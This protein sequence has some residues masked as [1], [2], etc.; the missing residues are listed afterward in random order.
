MHD[1]Q[2][3]EEMKRIQKEV[4]ALTDINKDF[5]EFFDAIPEDLDEEGT[6]I[7]KKAF[8]FFHYKAI[9]NK[10]LINDYK[11]LSEGLDVDGNLAEK[12]ASFVNTCIEVMQTLSVNC[13]NNLLSVSEPKTLE[14]IDKNISKL[15]ALL[16]KI[17]AL[18][19]NSFS[20]H[21]LNN[22]FDTSLR[23]WENLNASSSKKLTSVVPFYDDEYLNDE[24]TEKVYNQLVT[25][26]GA[27]AS[28]I[29]KYN[30]DSEIFTFLA[31]NGFIESEKVT[32]QNA[33]DYSDTNT[34]VFHFSKLGRTAFRAV[35]S[36]N[37]NSLLDNNNEEIREIEG[38]TWFDQSLSV[39][40]LGIDEDGYSI[41]VRE[42][43]INERRSV[44]ESE[45]NETF[46]SIIKG[47][48]LRD[49]IGATLAAIIGSAGIYSMLFK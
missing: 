40:F 9:E 47:W 18:N 19:D 8:L 39:L 31:E 29:K 2:D 33:M 27:L 38:E 49:W 16:L 35:V 11:A 23:D 14:T 36:N 30:K 34:T 20:S 41:D 48:G 15:N 25:N 26:A 32:L 3:I 28:L 12:S 21:Y 22:D 4:I 6:Y 17:A 10:S 5:S 43:E 24:D 13:A 7:V 1:M 44:F 46:I 37:G 42:K 45:R